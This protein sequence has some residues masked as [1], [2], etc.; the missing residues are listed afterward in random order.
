M[1]AKVSRFRIDDADSTLL[2]ELPVKVTKRS[3]PSGRNSARLEN[4]HQILAN[5]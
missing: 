1:Q 3:S 2:F 5:V 4:G